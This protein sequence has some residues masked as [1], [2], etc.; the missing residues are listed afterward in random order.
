MQQ[1]IYALR[2]GSAPTRGG[3]TV[4]PERNL[5]ALQGATIYQHC[6][7]SSVS[8]S[9]PAM[10]SLLKGYSL[11]LIPLARRYLNT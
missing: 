3:Y 7:I 11:S 6:A 4:W 10:T 1:S 9:W 5:T 2:H 8:R